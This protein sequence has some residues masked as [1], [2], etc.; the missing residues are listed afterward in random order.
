MVEQKAP[1]LARVELRRDPP[2]DQHPFI[3]D[4]IIKKEDLNDK[5]NR[6]TEDDG[7]Y[8]LSVSGGTD[9]RTTATDSKTLEDRRYEN[10]LP[11]YED[12]L[13][14]LREM[15]RR[16]RRRKRH[17]KHSPYRKL[18]DRNRKHE[19]EIM[20]QKFRGRNKRH[21]ENIGSILLGD[22]VMQSYTNLTKRDMSFVLPNFL[23]EDEQSIQ[24]RADEEQATQQTMFLTVTLP[25]FIGTLFLLV[26]FFYYFIQSILSVWFVW[27]LSFLMYY[28]TAIKLFNPRKQN[29]I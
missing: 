23:S 2:I 11:R 24:P 6:T 7:I 13:P 17:H 21:E 9:K 12:K 22:K 10:L 5:K 3:N 25:T 1:S 27:E 26:F 16:R 18:K 20:R 15:K 4:R 28:T 14:H 29:L 19:I 8:F